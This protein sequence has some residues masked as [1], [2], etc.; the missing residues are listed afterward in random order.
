MLISSDIIAVSVSARDDLSRVIISGLFPGMISGIISDCFRRSRWFLCCFC[1]QVANF[2]RVAV[3]F[4]RS[5]RGLPACRVRTPID[6][7]D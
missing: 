2:S 4:S 1:G 6:K 5:F 7:L 3:R